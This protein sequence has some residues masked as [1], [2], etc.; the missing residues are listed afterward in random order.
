MQPHTPAFVRVMV[1]SNFAIHSGEDF[2]LWSSRLLWYCVLY[3]KGISVFQGNIP[4][5]PHNTDT[6]PSDCNF[7]FTIL[8][9]ANLSVEGMS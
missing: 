2:V 1:G 7:Y 8:V 6:H 3:S 4:K 5:V 9:Q